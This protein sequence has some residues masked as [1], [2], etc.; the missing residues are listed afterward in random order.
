[1]ASKRKLYW[2]K[3][4]V[5]LGVIPILLWAHDYGPDPGKSGVPGESNCTESQCHVGTALNGGPGSVS[6]TFP[7]ALS[8]VPGETQHLKVTIA[9]PGEHRAGF[10]LTARQSSSTTVQ[11]GSFTSSD[12]LTQVLCTDTSFIAVLEL[13]FPGSQTCPAKQ[14]L[15]YIEHNLTGESRNIGTGTESYEFDW[16]PPSTNVGNVILYV[17]GNAANGDTQPTGDHIYSKAYTLT[18]TAAGNPPTI[19]SVVTTSSQAAAIAQNTWLEV[20]GAD[21]SATITDWSNADFSK[22]LPTALAGVSVTV[23]GKAAPIYYVSP[24]Q[25]NLLAPLDSAAGSVAVQVSTAAGKAVANVTEQQTSPAFL[26]I[27]ASGHV[28]ARHLDFSLLGPAAISV[29]GYTFTPA[30]PGETILLYSTGFGQSNPPITDQLNGLGPLP[31][32]P[33]VTIGG[34]PASV[35]FAGLS[36]AGLYQFNVV[37]PSSTPDGEAPLSAS[38]NGNSTQKNVIVT[39]KH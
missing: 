14:P 34:V 22:G 39:V 6:V 23:N 3:T 15:G 2:A 13:D 20:H 29:P 18:P 28:A 27:D 35:A 16:S 37:V 4:G 9:D 11:A 31:T 36:G 38:Y 7:G 24:T 10:Q 30:K 26:V 17:E 19:S 32:L 1:M 5:I 8:Y 33:A 21:L 25:V 12:G